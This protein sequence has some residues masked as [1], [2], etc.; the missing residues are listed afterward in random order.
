MISIRWKWQNKF[1]LKL[2]LLPQFP[3]WLTEHTLG[4]GSWSSDAGG[5]SRGGTDE[6]YDGQTQTYT[7]ACLGT[8]N[9][10]QISGHISW[11][12]VLG[13]KVFWFVKFSCNF[14]VCDICHKMWEHV[15]N[16]WG[17]AE[18]VCAAR[19]KSD[20]KAGTGAV[21]CAWTHLRLRQLS[22]RGSHTKVA[23]NLTQVTNKW[24]KSGTK[25][26]KSGTKFDTSDTQ[27]RQ[28]WHKTTQKWHKIW[29]KWHWSQVPQGRRAWT[30]QHRR[31]PPRLARFKYTHGC[32][33]HAQEYLRLSHTQFYFRFNS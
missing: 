15:E 24:D 21:R 2:L 11:P 25:L 29:H 16:L 6:I 20:T 23:Q 4:W 33:S 17:D 27:V 18:R 9:L 26:H 10:W 8:Q 5:R 28:K 7:D 19:H 13:L 31:Q 12:E 22:H 3:R 1:D 32:L 30:D 14:L